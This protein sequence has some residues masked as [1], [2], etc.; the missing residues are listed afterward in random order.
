MAALFD[1]T[2]L[3]AELRAK[4]N[5]K[6]TVLGALAEII[7]NIFGEKRGNAE[8]GYIS[9][10]PKSRT[11]TIWDNGQGTDHIGRMFQF[12]NTIG[13]GGFDPG[14]YGVGGKH[15]MLWLSSKVTVWSLRDG[16]VMYDTV[17]WRNWFTAPSWKNIGVSDE[18]IKATMTNTPAELLA[19]KHGVM[20]KM[21]LL[22]KRKFHETRLIRELSK[23]YATGLRNGKQLIWRTVHK[24]ELVE[25]VELK[26]P[27]V[28]PAADADAITF[29]L[30]IEH[31]VDEQVVHLP[32]QGAVYYQEST[33]QA[34]SKIQ[35]GYGFRTIRSVT[36]CFR[37]G[38]GN[39]KYSGL[40]ISGWLDLGSEWR[41]CLT[42]HKD[43]LDDELLFDKLMDYVFEQIKPL[44]KKSQ[45]KTFSLEFEDLALGLQQALS[46]KI[47]DVKVETGG[48]S[49]GRNPDPKPI[50]PH[51]PPGPAP[52]V[53][54]MPKHPDGEGDKPTTKPPTLRITIVPTSDEQMEGHLCRALISGDSINLFVNED[55]PVVQQAMASKPVNKMLMNQMLVDELAAEVVAL[56]DEG[57][58]INRLFRPVLAKSLN[59][60]ENARDKARSVTRAL[61]D[62]VRMPPVEALDA[63]E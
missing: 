9:Y 10:D 51:D 4:Q 49:G 37:S 43:E 63:A 60:M 23:L 3:P 42:A 50:I 40:G 46:T 32:V 54:P 16:K 27:F 21:Q 5:A 58:F 29:N 18:W 45:R 34:D 36:E 19:L 52:D 38:D 25:E 31:I 2:S 14:V 62:R 41:D 6:W 8:I 15:G 20:I 39:E 47:G 33:T 22:P 24:D 44:L 55:H 30:I 1:V 35:V 13:S 28:A 48:K 26:D 11:L 12:G 56:P 57:A 59:E 61:I 7:D 17:T 53:W